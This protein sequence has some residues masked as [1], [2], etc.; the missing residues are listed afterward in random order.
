M[1]AGSLTK[2]NIKS[3]NQEIIPNSDYLSSSY[4]VHTPFGSSRHIIFVTVY[5]DY[6]KVLTANIGDCNKNTP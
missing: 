6:F 4:S 3:N 2:E 1:I 5:Y